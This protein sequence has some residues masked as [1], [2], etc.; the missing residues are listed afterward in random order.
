MLVRIATWNKLLG[1]FY[2]G[3]SQPNGQVSP[4]I[5][6]APLNTNK[7]MNDPVHHTSKLTP[8]EQQSSIPY[9]ETFLVAECLKQEIII[10]EILQEQQGGHNQAMA[11]HCVGGIST[12]A[13]H[14]KSES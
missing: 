12:N 5:F 13:V 6:H 8:T 11:F 2:G 10:M 7:P 1:L 3:N 9:L 14:I 4:V